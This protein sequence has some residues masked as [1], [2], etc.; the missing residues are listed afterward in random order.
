MYGYLRRAFYG[1]L[2]IVA[3]L[4]SGYGQGVGSSRGLPGGSG[5]THMIQGHVYY[6]SGRA[7]EQGILVKLESGVLG[8]KTSMTDGT[9]TFIF[10]GLP[11]AEYAITV[12]AGPEYEILHDT[13]V[14][15]GTSAGGSVP[16]IGT[17]TML[18][19][20]LVPKGTTAAIAAA[21]AG[22]PKQ[23]VD[24]Y[25]KALQ[26]AHEGN[27]KKAVDLLN[28]AITLYPRF[29]IALSELG[30]QYLSLNEPQKAAEI[31][32]KALELEPHD[33][34]I[35]L[36]YGIALLNSKDFNGAEEHLRE[37]L[38][39]NNASPTAHMYLGITLLALSKDEKT[40]QFYPER[41]EEA[42][43]ELETATTLGKDEVA[44]AHRYLGGVYMGNKDYKRAAAE[45]ETYLKLQPKAPDA[46]KL[47]GM[48]EDL[49]NRN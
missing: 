2:I 7:A 28:S 46:E 3:A 44:M 37:A 15:Y 20:Q 21:F 48:I 10:N 40:K 36:T 19:L 9:G 16:A 49:K 43:K 38:K 42:Q 18:N 29:S 13:V 22:V 5:G 33:F 27:H 47:R 32:K 35:Q 23:A 39:T 1:V 14:I 30:T 45:L 4:T 8:I 25:K 12:D 17:G 31:L 41:Y 26:S 11:A 24:D 34:T 6:P